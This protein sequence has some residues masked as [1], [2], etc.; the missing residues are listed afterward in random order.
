MVGIR[1]AATHGPETEMSA[2]FFS[3]ST[4]A[5]PDIWTLLSHVDDDSGWPTPLQ[6]L[7]YTKGD[8]LSL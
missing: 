4:D 1:G 6:I 2:T 3:S 5:R 7:A 8:W